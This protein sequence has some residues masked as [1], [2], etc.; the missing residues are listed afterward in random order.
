MIS[1]VTR[2]NEVLTYL[3]DN[4]PLFSVPVKGGRM[5]YRGQKI[6]AKTL[7]A[8]LNQKMKDPS[9]EPFTHGLVHGFRKQDNPSPEHKGIPFHYKGQD[10]THHGVASIS[11]MYWTG[12]RYALRHME[13]AA[14]TAMGNIPLLLELETTKEN[15][16]HAVI[17]KY[18]YYP[19]KFLKH[20]PSSEHE[21]FLDPEKNS[22]CLSKVIYDTKLKMWVAKI[23]ASTKSVQSATPK[24]PPQPAAGSNN[25]SQ[26]VPQVGTIKGP[27]AF[28]TSIKSDKEKLACWQKIYD[29]LKG[30]PDYILSLNSR[31]Q[32]WVET[33]IPLHNFR[34]SNDSDHNVLADVAG[35]PDL[36]I[37][38]YSK[39][40]FVVVKDLRHSDKTPHLLILP[41]PV[42]KGN[43]QDLRQF[44]QYAPDH[45]KIALWD[46]MA[47]LINNTRNMPDTTTL[48]RTN[49]GRWQ[50]I[51]YFN[52]HYMPYIKD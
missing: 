30:S 21:M 23:W 11:S 29:L 34:V 20:N 36:H 26:P 15:P 40:P 4:I 22:Y 6:N 50:S 46:T 5:Y 7:D 43:Y 18:N 10:Y 25:F 9:N 3:R 52:V 16:F 17:P 37:T 35:S 33:A 2:S 39:R 1:Y 24:T 51:P 12:K 48:F 38:H 14:V 27:F 19:R 31:G 41:S 47:E 13:P 32:A 28:D 42:R 8:M 45:Q 49:G 44:L